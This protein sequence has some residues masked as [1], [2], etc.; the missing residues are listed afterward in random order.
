[1][2][3]KL[4]N[5]LCICH[6]QQSILQRYM[7][8]GTF[9]PSPENSFNSL[10]PGN[11]IWHCRY[12]FTFFRHCLVT[13]QKLHQ[14]WLIVNEILW[15]SP[16]GIFT[17]N[18]WAIN[19]SNLIKNHTFEILAELTRGRQLKCTMTG[20]QYKYKQSFLTNDNVKGDMNHVDECDGINEICSQHLSL[21]VIYESM[22]VE[23]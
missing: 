7:L 19:D 2:W 14:C 12:R 11:T 13:K 8:V 15:H 22:F 1:M 10:W 6:Q 18:S 9:F 4:T 3:W 17:W 16:H 20:V 23:I 5:T 21:T